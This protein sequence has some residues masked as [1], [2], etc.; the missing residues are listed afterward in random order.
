MWTLEDS[1]EA[2]SVGGEAR[3]PFEIA[4]MDG[5]DQSG[6]DEVVEAGVIKVKVS[7]PV[8]GGS[9]IEA[10][11]TRGGWSGKGNCW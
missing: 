7:D 8:S 3:P 10:V 11:S 4:R 5:F 2:D 6:Y 9:F 1:T